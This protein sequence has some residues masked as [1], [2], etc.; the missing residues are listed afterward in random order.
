MSQENSTQKIVLSN[1]NLEN[2]ME[3]FSKI[4]G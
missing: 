3:I 1:I 2:N 4:S